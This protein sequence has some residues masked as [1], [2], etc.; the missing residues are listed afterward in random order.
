M[1]L[2]KFENGAESFQCG[3]RG[4]STQARFSGRKFQASWIRREKIPGW[5]SSLSADGI[6]TSPIAFSFFRSLSA[7]PFTPISPP[8]A[9]S[10]SSPRRVQKSIG[11]A[12]A[13]PHETIG[14]FLPPTR[15]VNVH[16]RLG[17]HAV[18]LYSFYSLDLS[19][20]SLGD[21]PPCPY[22]IVYPFPLHRTVAHLLFHYNP[23]LLQHTKVEDINR[24][25]T[26]IIPNQRILP[27]FIM[28]LRQS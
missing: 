20:Q 17:R 23:T 11:E 5:R 14:F 9:L 19:K 22:P 2:I 8:H 27:S 13:K 28:S 1:F 24:Q 18:N 4:A 26:S 7:S 25:C 3:V 15:R 21:N 6:I 10:I 16:P 12:T